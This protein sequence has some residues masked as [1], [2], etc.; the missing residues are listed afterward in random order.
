MLDYTG[1][2]VQ[3]LEGWQSGLMRRTRN[4]VGAKTPQRFKSST[5]RKINNIRIALIFF[6]SKMV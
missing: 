5:L 3:N 1:I 6:N 2:A 4:A